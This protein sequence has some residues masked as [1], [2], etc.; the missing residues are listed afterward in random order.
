MKL[1]YS[2]TDNDIELN[3]DANQSDQSIVKWFFKNNASAEDFRIVDELEGEFT[4]P[5]TMTKRGQVWVATVT[6]FD[7][8]MRMILWNQIQL[9]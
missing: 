6:P 2:F 7:V 9:L 3:G 4:V 5:S 8:L 1:T